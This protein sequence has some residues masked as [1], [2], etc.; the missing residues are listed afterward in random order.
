MYEG[1]KCWYCNDT[2]TMQILVDENGQVVSTTSDGWPLER[3]I[4][5][6]AIEMGSPQSIY[7]W[8]PVPCKH[9][10]LILDQGYIVRSELSK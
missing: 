6:E 10:E 5:G 9:C 4:A 7:H 2:G 8:K 3:N 1:L